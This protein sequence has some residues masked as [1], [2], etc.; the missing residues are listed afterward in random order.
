M[1]VPLPM[2]RPLYP[3]ALAA[4][5]RRHWGTGARCQFHP[6]PAGHRPHLTGFP[7]PPPH[8]RHNLPTLVHVPH[9]RRSAFHPHPTSG[10]QPHHHDPLASRALHQVP[11]RHSRQ[12]GC[13]RSVPRRRLHILPTQVM[14]RKRTQSS[15][16][17]A[18][19]KE[20]SEK[21]ACISVRGKGDSVRLAAWYF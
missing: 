18:V 3:N 16:V 2:I 14:G 7:E 6:L 21:V 15:V 10:Q 20:A 9:P 12:R 5:L 17:L 4:R 13:R 8:R 11:T 19:G 1:N